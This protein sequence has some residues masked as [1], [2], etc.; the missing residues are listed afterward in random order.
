MKERMDDAIS[1]TVRLKKSE[2]DDLV[3]IAKRKEC[4]VKTVARR[5]VQRAI[6]VEKISTMPACAENARGAIRR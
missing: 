1:F 6:F 5:A 2:F 3:E 4:S